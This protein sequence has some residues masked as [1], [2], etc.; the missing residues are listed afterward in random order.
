MKSFSR[1][2]VIA[3]FAAL[4]VVVVNLPAFAD[5]Y[6]TADFSG[7]I[8]GGNANCQPPFDTVISQGGPISGHFVYDDNLIP[9]AGSGFVNVPF[10]SFP[11]I[12]QIPAA[13]AFTINLGDPSLTFTL[14][15]AIPGSGAIQYNNG[16]FN[17][18]SFVSDFTFQSNPYE[19]SV[20]GG[21]WNIVA[22]VGGYPT[23]SNLVSGYINITDANLTNIQPF[24]PAPVPAPATLLLLGSGLAGL[25]GFRRKF[26][27]S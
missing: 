20:S 26:K 1:W 13:T 10:S 18:F 22:I 19:L 27:K 16:H 9:A 7:A 23:F 21:T 5:T 8:F 25:A 3:I 6:H 24:T 4:L 11:A 2:W 14:A 15:D 12:P 17:G